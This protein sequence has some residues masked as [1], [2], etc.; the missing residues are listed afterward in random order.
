VLPADDTKAT[1]HPLPLAYL[2]GAFLPL[3]E[4]RVPALDRGFLFGDSV[5]EV[6][7][8]YG[9][10]L[11]LLDAHSASDANRPIRNAAHEEGYMKHYHP[12]PRT[13]GHVFY[14]VA[15]ALT[16]SHYVE[17][18]TDCVT[19]ELAAVGDFFNPLAIP[20]DLIDI[21]ELFREK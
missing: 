7:P 4:A 6:V 15:A 21:Y 16:L 2:N 18:C 12:K 13:G 19:D 3:A 9:G 10:R 14:S 20:Q 17:E 1:V 5:Y 8:V 11:F